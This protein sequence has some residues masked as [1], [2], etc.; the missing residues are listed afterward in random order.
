VQNSSAID[1]V[2]QKEAHCGPA[3]VSM[4]GMTYDLSLSQDDIAA[5]AGMSDIIIDAEGMRLDELRDG[6][7][8]LFPDGAYRLLAKYQST[9]DDLDHLT[10]TLGLPAGVEWQGRFANPDGTRTDQG[11]YS[12]I[13]GVD[14][15]QGVLSVVDPEDQNILTQQGQLP[16]ATFEPRWWEVDIVPLP[17]DPGRS[18][19][20]EMERLIF[21]LAAA[22]QAPALRELGF[23][24]ATLDVMW[25]HATLLE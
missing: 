7:R 24:P 17:H 22:D 21:V 2:Q 11:H 12:V 16:I 6:I 18:K 9:I 10:G 4:L 1:R 19:V 23:R 15:Q 14:R 13:T 25:Q 5:A 8:A 20:I 3:T